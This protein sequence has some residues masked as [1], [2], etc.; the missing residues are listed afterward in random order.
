MTRKRIDIIVHKTTTRNIQKGNIIRVSYGY[1]RNYLLPHN[2]GSI[3]TRS[4]LLKYYKYQT[5]QKQKIAKQDNSIHKIK[6]LLEKVGKLSIIKKV[7]K[8]NRF[9]G[10][11]ASHNVIS[12]L[13]KQTNV[14]LNKKQLTLPSIRTTGLS[15]VNVKLSSDIIVKINIQII[16]M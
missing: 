1:A 9:F 2:I 14:L 3:A 4:V 7:G 15:L 8:D 12:I 5:A 6:V 16:P 13:L 11:I 10:S